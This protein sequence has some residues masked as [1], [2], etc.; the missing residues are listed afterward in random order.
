MQWYL[1]VMKQYA[2][3]SGRARRKEYWMF[4]L[5]Y[6]AIIVVATIIDSVIG[7]PGVVSGIV[8]LV[9]IIPSLAAAVRR[10]HDTGRSGWAV[11]IF[12]VPFV[13]VFIAIYWLTQDSKAG[14][15]TY[16]ANPKGLVAA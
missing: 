15:N 13:G 2:T 9:H 12:L 5:V 3:F 14:D 4:F 1:N 6:I 7:L 11:L 10:M 8:A 16:G